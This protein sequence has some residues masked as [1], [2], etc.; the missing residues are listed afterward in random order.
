MYFMTAPI[1]S[2]TKA[3]I[4]FGSMAIILG[5]WPT[6]VPFQNQMSLWKITLCWIGGTILI[7]SGLAFL[8]VNPEND[9]TLEDS[10]FIYK[11]GRVYTY[12]QKCLLTFGVLFFSVLLLIMCTYKINK[13][14]KLGY[15]TID[16]SMSLNDNLLSTSL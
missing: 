7:S 5:L 13:R 3:R 15:N 4:L 6:I 1:S 16:S 2:V 11:D 9:N 10:N 14:V 12:V 8:L